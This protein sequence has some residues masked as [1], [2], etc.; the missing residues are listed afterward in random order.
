MKREIWTCWTELMTKKIE[1][2]FDSGNTCTS[3]TTKDTEH[4]RGTKT[5]A[6]KF[7]RDNRNKI[8]ALRIGKLI[9]EWVN[10]K[11]VDR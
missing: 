8:P 3:F 2:S 10:G 6:Y 4:F 11:W 9:L 5:A 7:Y 1:R